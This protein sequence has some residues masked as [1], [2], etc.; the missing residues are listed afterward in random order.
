MLLSNTKYIPV[1]KKCRCVEMVE[2][3]AVILSAPFS[4]LFATDGNTVVT[5]ADISISL[6]SFV[7]IK[8]YFLGMSI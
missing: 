6:V 2:Y 3:L 5:L 8:N 7:Y 4:I 1:V